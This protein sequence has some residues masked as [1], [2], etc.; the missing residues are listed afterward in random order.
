MTIITGNRALIPL[1]EQLTEGEG[2]FGLPAE[3]HVWADP[4]L[5]AVGEFAIAQLAH[6]TGQ[7]PVWGEA[8]H[9]RLTASDE[10]DL[11][12]EGYRLTVTPTGITIAAGA[13]AGAF[14]GV[15]TVLQMWP[16]GGQGDI[17]ACEVLDRPRFAYRGAMLDVARHFFPPD[18]VRQVIDWMAAYK[19]NHLH[20]HL[21]DDQ[22][23]RIE[24]KT[25]PN[26]TTLGAQSA[27]G[28]DS[29]GFYTQAEY[30]DLV[31]YAQARFIAIVPEIDMPGHTN[32]ALAS[33]PELNCDGHAPAPYTGIEVGFSSFCIDHEPTYAFLDDVIREVAALTPSP[34]FH[35]GGD[36]PH[37]TPPE[38]YRRFIARV[39]SIV[40]KYGKRVVGWEEIGQAELVAG[41]VVQHW[42]SDFSRRAVLQGAKVICSPATRVYLDIKYDADTPIGLQWSGLTD[43]EKSYDWE[44]STLM[45]GVAEADILG[46]EAPLWTE[47]V[48]T[49]ADIAYLMFPRLLSAAEIG[50]SPREG[51]GWG[52]YRVRLGRLGAYLSAQGIGFHRDAA[53]PWA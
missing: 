21:T 31:A 39:Q 26:L 16:V 45:E 47:T 7:T 44:P 8:A 40:Q 14:Y 38:D 12:D 13:P 53:V 51:R 34:L 23:W 43:T 19:L 1:P 9:L 49:R 22:G 28:G 41:A 52:E 4:A 48:R 3:L 36:E 10:A 42:F 46:V 6:L 25:W 29:G 37:A 30:A 18:D 27:V 2:A 24:I 35:I 5:R 33:Y 11:G 20:L 17:A 32:A 15:Q 50:W